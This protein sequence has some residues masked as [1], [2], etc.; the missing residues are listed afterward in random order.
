MHL[1]DSANE[2]LLNDFLSFD[3]KNPMAE[4]ENR[5]DFFTTLRKSVAENVYSDR[6]DEKST[7]TKNSTTFRVD[8]SDLISRCRTFLPLMTDANRIL[9]SKI[10][11]GENVQIDLDS[12]DESENEDENEEKQRIEMNLMFC[13]DPNVDEDET[14]SSSDDEILRSTIKKSPE[15]KIVEIESTEKEEK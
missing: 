3:P 7:S 14:S 8:S 2:F 10:Q 15:K 12:E 5:D 1:I 11:S 9:M 6:Q 4:D 13:P